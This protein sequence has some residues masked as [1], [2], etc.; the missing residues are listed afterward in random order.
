[1]SSKTT[2]WYYLM[3]VFI[4]LILTFPSSCGRKDIYEGIY[5]AQ[6]EET[7]KYSGNQLE[8]MEKGQAVWR[9]TDDEVSFKWDIKGSE[10][11]LSTKSGGIIIGEIHGNTIDITLPGAKKM[12][13]K[14]Y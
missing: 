11:W 9:V 3:P 5:K 4:F 14:K 2:K 1:M 12:S 10:I 8:L 13:F 7:A 6:E